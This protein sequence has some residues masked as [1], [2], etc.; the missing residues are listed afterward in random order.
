MNRII[1]HHNF[2]GTKLVYKST[3]NR[4]INHNFVGKWHKR[5]FLYSY[6]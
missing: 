5:E 3:I 6:L 2:D 4:N 1:K